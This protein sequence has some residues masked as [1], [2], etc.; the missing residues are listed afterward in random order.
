LA[1]SSMLAV[2]PQVFTGAACL[3]KVNFTVCS[4]PSESYTPV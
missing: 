3:V 1:P 2:Q 4:T